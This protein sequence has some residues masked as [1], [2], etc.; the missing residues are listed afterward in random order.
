M[1]RQIFQLYLDLNSL[2][3][4]AEALAGRGV[5]SRPRTFAS[6]VPVGGRPFRTGA[7]SHL[8]GNRMYLGEVNHRGCSYPG[9]HEPIIPPDM[10]AAVQELLAKRRNRKHGSSGKSRA[11]LGGLILDDRGNRMTAVHAT[12]GKL[13]YRYYQ[14]WV[15]GH[16][17]KD[18]AGSVARVPAGD[19]ERLVIETLASRFPD[20]I[21]TFEALNTQADH[22]R[23][24]IG[25]VII[26]PQHIEIEL[27]A[28]L[29]H[30]SRG[31]CRD[32]FR[33]RSAG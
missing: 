31:S 9:E 30:N 8:L 15:L 16:G 5:V 28:S 3:R 19:V 32:S 13:R 11:L 6:G 33:G 2:P 14:S 7:L 27:K 17:Q 23:A 21:G 26:H 12:K 29:S 24:T 20:N 4:L 10:F 18:K 25:R 1:V 22:V